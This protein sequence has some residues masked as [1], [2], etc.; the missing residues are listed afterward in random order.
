LGLKA[1]LRRLRFFAVEPDAD[2]IAEA[3]VP[4][5]PDY[6]WYGVIEG[7]HI[8]QGDIVESCPI[9]LPPDNLVIDAGGKPSS[10]T[11]KWKE[12]DL[13]V[14]SQS[15]DLVK[16]R[17]KVDDILLCAIWRRSELA[18]DPHLGKDSGMEDARKGRMPAFHVLASC[19]IPGFEREVRVV[20]FR[21]VYSLPVAFVRSR[22]RLSERLR[23]LPPYREHLSQS[24]ARF[25]MRVGLPIDIPPFTAKKA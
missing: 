1:I 20:D 10:A 6:P 19:V 14:M 16:G 2:R 9:F 18:I 11:F 21:R 12:Q 3:Q 7:D 24:F 25:F 5:I 23:L 15:C 8:E 22:T 13:I 17:E 4:G